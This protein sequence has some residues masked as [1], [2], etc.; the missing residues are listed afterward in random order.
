MNSYYCVLPFYSVETSFTNTNKNIFCC[1][2][3]P[4]TDIELVRSSIK[5]QTRSPNCSTCWALEDAG[6]RSERQIHNE[7]MDF[8]LDLNIENIENT[9]ITKGFDPVNIKLAT[10]NLCNGTCVTC[11]SDNSSAWGALEN[12]GSKYKSMNMSN[13]DFDIDWAKVVSLSL[14]GGEPLLEKKNF[15]ILENLIKH[16]NTECFISFVTNGSVEL[17]VAQINLLNQFKRLNICLSI[18]GTGSVFEYM[19]YPLK[20]DRLVHNMGLFKQL[21]ADV[22]VSCM[23]SNLNIYY[24]SDMID[25]FKEHKLNYLCKQVLDPYIFNPS[26]LP[27]EAKFRVIKNN[28]GFQDEVTKLLNMYEFNADLYTQFQQEIVRQD[29]LKNI[30][31]VDYMYLL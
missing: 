15:Q 19:R 3:L 18:D 24:Y 9:S 31:I 8:L 10:S 2:L 20:W 7:T 12:T 29:Q 22:S 14:V 17:S 26:N 1:R 30:N 27:N 21:G 5:N 25:F 23:I 6:L 13:L 28:P 4:N 11:N 16:N